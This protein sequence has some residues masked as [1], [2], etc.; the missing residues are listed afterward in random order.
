MTTEEIM[1]RAVD[2]FGHAHQI[3]KAME[4]MAEL[5]KEICK[6]LNEAGI[7]QE[8]MDNISQ[9]IA[10]VEIMLEQLKIIFSNQERVEDWKKLKLLRL[11][12]RLNWK[13]AQA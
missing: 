13:G 5:Q 1:E 9:E 12:Y 7:N 3:I 6:Y 10:D 2:T 4:E 8:R 11:E